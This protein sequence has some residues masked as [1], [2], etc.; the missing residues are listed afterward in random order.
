MYSVHVVPIDAQ[1]EGP[2][3]CHCF[4]VCGTPV[5]GSDRCESCATLLAGADE[6]TAAR[7]MRP[8]AAIGMRAE[9]LARFGDIDGALS[10]IVNS[11]AGFNLH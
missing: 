8:L 6:R 7:F 3:C 9:A 1:V 4:N 11:L 2:V 10:E 5:H